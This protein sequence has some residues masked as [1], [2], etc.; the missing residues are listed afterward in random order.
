MK[1]CE[2]ALNNLEKG[3][4]LSAQGDVNFIRSFSEAAYWL[5]DSE[6][7]EEEEY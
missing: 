4:K 1:S 6:I 2:L 3:N 7:K 5:L